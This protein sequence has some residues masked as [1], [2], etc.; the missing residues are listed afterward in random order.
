MIPRIAF[1][2]FDI[3]IDEEH[4]IGET[5]SNTPGIMVKIKMLVEIED[6]GNGTQETW[7]TRQWITD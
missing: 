2:R 6:V 7:L 1:E 5:E 4:S 3:A